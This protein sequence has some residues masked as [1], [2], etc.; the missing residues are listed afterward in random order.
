[1]VHEKDA[2]DMISESSTLVSNKLPEGHNVQSSATYVLDA[3]PAPT[4]EE[5]LVP[6]HPPSYLV[7]QEP[8]G[9]PVPVLPSVSVAERS[10]VI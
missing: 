9:F 10:E 5:K 6:S 3:T 8:A 2:E 4:I 7:A 1:M